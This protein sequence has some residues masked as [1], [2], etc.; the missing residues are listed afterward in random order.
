MYSDLY[1]GKLYGYELAFPVV[2]LIPVAAVT[3][4]AKHMP[5]CV[6]NACGD[7]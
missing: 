6:C 2:K 3:P 1:R 5:A 7:V 4:K